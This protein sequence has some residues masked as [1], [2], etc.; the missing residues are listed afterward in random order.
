MTPS[1]PDSPEEADRIL[2]ATLYLMSCHARNG[3]PR[4]ACMIER[5]LALLAK[6]RGSGCHVADTCRK[7]SCAW[8]AIAN[9]DEVVRT[10]GV[11]PGLH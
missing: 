8:R 10:P 3:C 2:A 11:K 5:H 9:H 7:L 6:H 1:H 4:L